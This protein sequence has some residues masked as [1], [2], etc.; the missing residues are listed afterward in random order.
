MRGRSSEY[1]HLFLEPPY[2][3]D[4]LL[5]VPWCH[6]FDLRHISEFPM[7]RPHTV[8]GRHVERR[9]TVMVRVIDLVDQR[10]TVIGSGSPLTLVI[11]ELVGSTA[12]EPDTLTSLSESTEETPILSLRQIAP[13]GFLT[14]GFAADWS[15]CTS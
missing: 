15:G 2:I 5:D 8:R 11:P 3:F 9:I 14:Q 12:T 13:P 1:A 7:V 6:A 4:D 10:R